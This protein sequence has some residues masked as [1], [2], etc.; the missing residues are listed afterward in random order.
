M[1]VKIELT[2][3]HNLRLF[4]KRLKD[5]EKNLPKLNAIRDELT[6]KEQNIRSEKRKTDNEIRSLMQ[7]HIG[8]P[9]YY[10]P[11]MLRRVDPDI[12]RKNHYKSGLDKTLRFTLYQ[13]QRVR[14]AIKVCER[15]TG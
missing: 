3:D 12:R 7:R 1:S 11:N 15:N 14:H 2:N 13:L 8:T 4:Y 6:Q 9:V 5:N 10:V